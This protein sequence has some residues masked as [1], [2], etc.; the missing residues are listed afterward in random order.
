MRGEDDDRRRRWSPS[1]N[2]GGPALSLKNSILGPF[3]AISH[4]SYLRAADIP[5]ILYI[6]CSPPQ[7]AGEL[8]HMEWRMPS[9]RLA[10][11][12]VRIQF[13]RYRDNLSCPK[14]SYATYVSPSNRSLYYAIYDGYSQAYIPECERDPD[15]PKWV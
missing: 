1:V 12:K 2:A 3:R 14:G 6:E 11:T 7:G 9:I 10:P 13:T 5:F 4:E 15:G 8:S